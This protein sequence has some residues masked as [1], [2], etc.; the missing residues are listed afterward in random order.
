MTNR[1]PTMLGEAETSAAGEHSL[2]NSRPET[3][4]SL[5]EDMAQKSGPSRFPAHANKPRPAFFRLKLTVP[6]TEVWGILRTD[7]E[8]LT[9]EY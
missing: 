3:T 9:A 2:G 6:Q 1:F 4:K 7:H 5:N 8:E